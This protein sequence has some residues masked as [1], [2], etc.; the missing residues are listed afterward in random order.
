VIG[1]QSTG[2]TEEAGNPTW[3]FPRQATWDFDGTRVTASVLVLSNCIFNGSERGKEMW[4][5]N[6]ETKT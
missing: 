4:L 6:E 3:S 1:S 2:S 5:A